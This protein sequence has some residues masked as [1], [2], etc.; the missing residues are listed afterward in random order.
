MKRVLRYF[1][2][3]NRLLV[4]MVANQVAACYLSGYHHQVISSLLHNVDYLFTVD[5]TAEML[6]MFIRIAVNI[7]LL[8]VGYKFICRS[9]FYFVC[10]SL[11]SSICLIIAMYIQVDFVSYLSWILN[12][13]FMGAIAASKDYIIFIEAV[14][15]N[16]N[17]P[18]I[19]ALK[20]LGNLFAILHIYYFF[21]FK[22]IMHVHGSVIL[23]CIGSVILI[24]SGSMFVNILEKIY[25]SKNINDTNIKTQ[26]QASKIKYNDNY[27]N[28]QNITINTSETKDEQH[29]SIF[30]KNAYIRLCNTIKN[31]SVQSSLLVFFTVFCLLVGHV[32]DQIIY[33]KQFD[34][35]KAV[36][37]KFIGQTLLGYIYSYIFSNSI[38][39][40]P[41]STIF[42][43]L[44]HLSFM[45]EPF[46]NM[47]GVILKGLAIHLR[48]TIYILATLQL[49]SGNNAYLLIAQIAEAFSMFVSGC[50]VDFNIIS[51]GYMLHVNIIIINIV[52]SCLVMLIIFKFRKK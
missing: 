34:H 37:Y 3:Y 7:F 30:I 32:S 42:V 44:S 38:L 35:R 18:M 10:I 12:R 6:G 27:I 39:V 8:S 5:G 43:V 24:F 50:L 48:N 41:M 46:N 15:N 52:C 20:T 40:I 2:S 17:V 11:L 26:T 25:E 14:N 21:D 45:H 28:N 51:T 47:M 19:K 49:T 16:L 22:N 29:I 23:I 33:V 31:V 4:L 1:A 9:Y 13:I 36:Q